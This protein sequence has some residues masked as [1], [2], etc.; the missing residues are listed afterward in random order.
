MQNKFLRIILNKPRDTRILTLHKIARIPTV[1]E[2]IRESI[3]RAY[4]YTHTN[5]LIAETGNYDINKIPLKIRVK[6]PK[7]MLQNP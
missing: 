3:S 5:P 1:Q 7:H 2:Y 4:N 6:L